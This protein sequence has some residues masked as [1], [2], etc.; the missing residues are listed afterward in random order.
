L[1][2]YT[3]VSYTP[4]IFLFFFNKSCNELSIDFGVL[5]VPIKQFIIDIKKKKSK[6]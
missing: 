2:Q 4:Y 6:V 1:K 5:V 3:K